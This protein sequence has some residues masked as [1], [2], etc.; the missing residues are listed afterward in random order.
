MIKKTLISVILITLV[1]SATVYALT[2]KIASYNVQNL[3]DMHNNGSEYDQY[4]PGEY[5]WNEKIL[6]IKVANLA[7]VISDLNADVIALQEVETS[8]VLR[9]LQR[10]LKAKGLHYPYQKIAGAKPS[11][12]KCAVL[13]KFPII[14]TQEIFVKKGSRTILN[15]TLSI[16][17]QPLILFV[18]HWKSKRGPESRRI[19]YAKA[20]KAE[21][22]ALPLQTDFI[23]LGDLNSN[24]N[25]YLT[26]R[27][28]AKLNDTNGRTGINHIIGTIQNKRMVDE[29]MLTE[30][31]AKALMYN[32][33]LESGDR[34]RWSY[35]YGRRKD[36]IDNIIVPQSL[37]DNR[38]VSYQDNS[39]AKFDPPYL[40]K[41]NYIYRW[42]LA[43]NGKGRHKGRGFSDH[44]PIYAMF[45]TRSF[46]SET[47]A[48]PVSTQPQTTSIANLYKVNAGQV[49]YLL[50][51]CAVIYKHNGNAIIKQPGGR[52]VF[53]YRSGAKLKLGKIYQL[54]VK[55]L[56]DYN[57]L[58]EI[59]QIAGIRLI[60]AID[61]WRHYWLND[62]TTDLNE[63]RLQ[64]EVIDKIKGVYKHGFLHY[65]GN[66]KIRL[67]F[68]K[69]SAL[70]LPDNVSVVLRRVRIGFYN[71]PQIVIEKAGQI[72]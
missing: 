8:R 63:I 37:Y 46:V 58:R 67:H 33:W 69:N 59:T 24:Y 57:G 21:I 27:E 38:G 65:G 55:R 56:K 30:Q 41:N 60:G 61:K 15:V 25:E 12:V 47:A 13:S 51:N 49:N 62:L 45:T 39:F 19:L 64:N 48:S 22:D 34:D 16:D 20:L 14:G 7:R 53:V 70:K 2:F 42:Q 43:D 5:G 26:F 1:V 44:L 11:T 52:A 31:T 66:R 23:I 35:Q 40:F 50:D 72:K 6:R 36:S 9:R 28:D 29:T 17:K 54:N 68:K 3:F 32:L 4:I 71:H 10:A 18:N